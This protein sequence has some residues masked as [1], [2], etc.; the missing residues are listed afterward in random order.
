[1]T[2]EAKK[3]LSEIIDRMADLAK[4]SHEIRKEQLKIRD[5]TSVIRARLLIDIAMA[6]DDKGKPVYSN[7]QLREAALTLRLDE[8]EEYQRL[9]ERLRELDDE[10]Q[11]LAIEHNRLANRR[12]L[13]MME[14]GLVSP[15]S[16]EGI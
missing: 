7:E 12:M 4:K 1:M 8:N 2:E 11:A 13:L 10:G 5:R 9:K 15:P 14:M 6:K 3:E 16:P